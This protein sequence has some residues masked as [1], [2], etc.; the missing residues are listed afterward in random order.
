MK[1]QEI[2]TITDLVWDYF[3][4]H[5]EKELSPDMVF[6]ALTNKHKKL[7]INYSSINSA[8]YRFHLQKTI[9]RTSRGRYALKLPLSKGQL[10]IDDIIKHQTGGE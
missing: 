2:K 1:T 6:K 7:K 3:N 5:P 8:I 9:F 10:K 4:E